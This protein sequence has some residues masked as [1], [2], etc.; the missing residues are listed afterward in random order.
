M[1]FLGTPEGLHFLTRPRSPGNSET[2]TAGEA[3]TSLLCPPSCTQC[4]ASPLTECL[5]NHFTTVSSHRHGSF[6][7]PWA[8]LCHHSSL[9]ISKGLAYAQ[10]YSQLQ[11]KQ[12][13]YTSSSL[14]RIPN[15]VWK[16]HMVERAAELVA[17][18]PGW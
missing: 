7:H 14:K 8:S 16:E 2:M 17:E 11:L 15:C 5:K 1:L 3:V 10:I 13:S 9:V 6:N 18:N 4:S 12:C